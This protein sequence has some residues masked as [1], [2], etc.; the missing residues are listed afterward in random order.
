MQFHDDKRLSKY[1]TCLDAINLYGWAM[2]QYLTYG[3]LECSN[4]KEINKSFFTLFSYEN[5][6]F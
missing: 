3:E 2:S 4:Q 5:S 6:V 1:I